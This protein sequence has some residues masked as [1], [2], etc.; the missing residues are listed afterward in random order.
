M[1]PSASGVGISTLFVC[2]EDLPPTE[3]RTM[4][5]EVSRGV[6]VIA[7]SATLL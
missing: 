6:D 2:A 4:M 5:G 3:Q 7:L 1:Q